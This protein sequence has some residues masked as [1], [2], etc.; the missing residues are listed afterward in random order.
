MSEINHFK[1]EVHE[2]KDVND[3]HVNGR[4]VPIWKDWEN[5]IKKVPQMVYVTEVKPGEMK[6]PHLHKI[7]T[8]YFVCIK[9][10]VVFIIRD[11]TGKY[12]EI[13]TSYENPNLIEIPKNY[14]ACHINLSTETSMVLALV[15]PAWRPDNRDEH[16]LSFD[17]YDFSK[18]E[19]ITNN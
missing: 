7:R 19:K 16:N 12:H 4:M 18:W 13:E 14:P 17:D 6:G 8:S 3:G 1:L 2:T 5:I 9:G 15:N 11:P 10:K